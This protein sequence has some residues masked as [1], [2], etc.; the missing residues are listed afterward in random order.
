MAR[1]RPKGAAACKAERW[2]WLRALALQGEREGVG[3]RS[4]RQTRITATADEDAGLRQTCFSETA[5]GCLPRARKRLPRSRRRRLPS[6]SVGVIGGA[7]C[8]PLMPPVDRR[9][10]RRLRRLMLRS[11]AALFLASCRLTLGGSR[12]LR[13]R[14]LGRRLRLRLRC[15]FFR[16]A[17]LLTVIDGDIEKCLRELQVTASRLLQHNKKISESNATCRRRAHRRARR[18]KR[19]ARR[20]I[21]AARDRIA[22]RSALYARRAACK[23]MPMK[24]AFL[25]THRR[26]ARRCGQRAHD[27]SARRDARGERV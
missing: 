27:P 20:L 7:V 13:S 3:E 19:A 12:L 23:E 18:S 25:A 10:S 8:D 14:L 11:A 22:D 4:E 17:V 21:A 26:A 15:C 9:S 6:N 16:H 2:N 5:P 24:W 1:G